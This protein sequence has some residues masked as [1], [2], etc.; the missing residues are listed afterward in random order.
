MTSSGSVNFSVSR[1]DII[2]Y[3]LRLVNQTSETPPNDESEYAALT[4]NAMIKEWVARG[5]K[6]WKTEEAIIFTTVGQESYQLG[7]SGDEACLVSDYVATTLSADEAA[8][9]T[10]LSV[11]SSAGMAAADVIGI[12]LDADTIDW[13]TIVSVDSATQITVTDALTGAAAS[14]NRLHTYTNILQRPLQVMNVRNS[15]ESAGTEIPY[16]DD[17]SRQEYMALPLKSAQGKTTQ[18]YYDPQLTNGRIYVWPVTDT[19]DDTIRCSVYLPLEDMDAAANTPDFPQEFY[20]ALSFGLA[21]LLLPEK[22]TPADAAS[23]IRAQA[24]ESLAIL[25]NW[26]AEPASVQFQP[27]M[28]P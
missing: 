28:G 11:T 2:K 18:F 26:D 9:Q 20:L 3:A 24:G 19:T 10:I 16:A 7:P 21:K 12:T 5:V 22:G 13:T 1:A 23:A 4:L 8:A 27:D 14:G 6:L 25:E 17:M 15:D